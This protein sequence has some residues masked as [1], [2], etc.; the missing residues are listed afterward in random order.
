MRRHRHNAPRRALGFTPSSTL[1][2]TLIEMVIVIAI[3]SILLSM[4]VASYSRSIQSAR[5]ASMKQN[6]FTLRHVI[7]E[8]TLD[9][10]RAPQSL[11]EIS[12]SGYLKEIPTDPCTKQK[13]W[14]VDQEDTLLAVDQNQPGITDVHSICPLRA[15]DGTAYSEW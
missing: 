1:G 3:I 10:Q 6:L 13:D 11:D 7:Q 4:A 15:A 12:Q 5:D 8:F 2:F 14:R 9:K